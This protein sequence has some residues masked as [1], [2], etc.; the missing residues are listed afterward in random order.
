TQAVSPAFRP[1]VTGPGRN[2]GPTNAGVVMSGRWVPIT[3]LSVG[4]LVASVVTGGP[5]PVPA[6]APPRPPH[7]HA[8]PPPT[9]ARRGRERN[10]PGRRRQAARPAARAGAPLVEPRPGRDP[11]QRLP[12]DARRPAPRGRLA[13][14]MVL[15]LHAHVSRVPVAVGHAARR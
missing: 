4:S 2:G 9:R 12:V 14:Q 7:I 11:R 15:A 13:P 3:I 6:Q 5:P 8:P 1:G 10:P